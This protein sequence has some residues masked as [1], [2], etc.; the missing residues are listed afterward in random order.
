MSISLV[1][2]THNTFLNINNITSVYI[3]LRQSCN[4][5]HSLGYLRKLLFDRVRIKGQSHKAVW[6]PRNQAV[7]STYH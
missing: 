4:L 3:S 5:K 2:V 6:V 7:L 1:C